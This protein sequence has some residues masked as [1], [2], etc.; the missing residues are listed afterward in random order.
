MG[1]KMELKDII[2]VATKRF[3]VP[4]A[5]INY[6]SWKGKT[7][8][9]HLEDGVKNGTIVIS[10]DKIFLNGKDIRSVGEFFINV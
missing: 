5:G 8:K 4:I 10:V 1:Y 3:N 9:E 2:E 6:S 7:L